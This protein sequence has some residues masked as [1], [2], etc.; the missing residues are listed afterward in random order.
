MTPNFL[1]A[2]RFRSLPSFVAI[3]FVAI[4]FL[5]AAGS[6]LLSISFAAI[7][8]EKIVWSDKE[9]PIV[10]QIRGLR[11][12]PDDVR[13][14][15]TKDTAMQIRQLPVS[16][17]KLRLAGALANLSTE[18]D[19][20][21][22]ALQ[23][24][25]NTLAAALREQPP[26]GKNGGLNDLYVELASLARYEHVSVASDNAQ[27]AAATAKLEAE[28]TQRQEADFTLSDLQGKSWRLKDLQGKVVLV[29]FWATWCP[30]CR[31]EM[32]DLQSLYVR[33]Q[34]QGFVVLAISDEENAKV[35][36]FIAERAITYPVLLDPGRKVNGLFQIEGIPKSF[37]YD[38]N[39]RLVVQSIDMRTQKQF[40]DMLA[41]A[42]LQ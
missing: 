15:T 37:V 17:N 33:F 36:P 9:R 14:R 32:P 38:R 26:T 6:L 11:A 29:N 18:G 20:G 22:E 23:E 1:R 35:A 25:A 24:V 3:I 27:F 31:K 34:G 41:Q 19:F 13:A 28:D 12:L 40:L 30:P 5:V 7:A 8:Q 39:G 2:A 42:G 4:V 10:E 16:P 21:H